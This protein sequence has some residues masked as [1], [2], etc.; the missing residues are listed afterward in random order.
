MDESAAAN[1]RPHP[2]D[3][4]PSDNSPWDTQAQQDRF[5]GQEEFPASSPQQ[6]WI[7]RP[8]EE[9]LYIIFAE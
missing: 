5:W 9:S 3:S 4:L 1:T 8:S 6:R 2:E 7:P